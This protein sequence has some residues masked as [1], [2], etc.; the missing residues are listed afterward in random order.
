[1]LLWFYRHQVELL[2]FYAEPTTVEEAVNV[3]ESIKL[4]ANELY[5]GGSF[6]EAARLYSR[7]HGYLKK[8]HVTSQL[9]TSILLNLLLVNN[10]LGAY[11]DNIR[12]ANENKVPITS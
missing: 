6:A 7:A 9:Y 12:L 10:K 3:S 1:M 4:Q 2:D 8:F 11:G 5:G